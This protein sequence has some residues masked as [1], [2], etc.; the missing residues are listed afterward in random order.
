MDLKSIDW[1]VIG[2]SQKDSYLSR[3]QI[4]KYLGVCESTVGR[5]ERQREL[6][7][8]KVG[9]RKFYKREEIDNWIKLP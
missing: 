1:D 2:I 8:Y 5:W 4:A 6:P 7:F 3:G 9:Q